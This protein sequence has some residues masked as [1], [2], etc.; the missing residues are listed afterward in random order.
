MLRLFIYRS[1]IY[2]FH[3]SRYIK[4]PILSALFPIYFLSTLTN[5]LSPSLS[6]HYTPHHYSKPRGELPAKLV[7]FFMTVGSGPLKPEQASSSSHFP[8]GSL[9]PADAP[10]LPPLPAN[11]EAVVLP[12]DV[13]YCMPDV[14]ACHWSAIYI[15]D[16]FVHSVCYLFCSL[17]A[18]SS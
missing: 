10:A 8:R 5:Q 2:V 13:D 1:Y 14:G 9:K 17:N 15:Y 3:T 18:I 16:C 4:S 11:C 6:N 7:D 12:A